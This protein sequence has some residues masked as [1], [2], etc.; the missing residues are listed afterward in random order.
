MKS[1]K[2]LIPQMKDKITQIKVPLG[3]LCNHS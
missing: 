2:S 1:E 3:N